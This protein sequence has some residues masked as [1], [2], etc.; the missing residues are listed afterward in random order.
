MLL[1]L[2][3]NTTSFDYTL[4]GVNLGSKRCQMLAGFVAHNQSLLSLHLSRKG[5]MDNEGQ[6]LAKMLLTNNTL[7]KLELEGNNLGHLS[8]YAFSRALKVNKGLKF[9]DLES[10]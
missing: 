10:N 3:E 4:S 6:D 8:A 5:I 9:L 7:R 1:D 2:Q